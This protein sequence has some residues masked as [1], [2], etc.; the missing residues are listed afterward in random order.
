MNLPR[1]IPAFAAGR[2]VGGLM[3][4]LLVAVPAGAQDLARARMA[5]ADGETALAAG[6]PEIALARFDEALALDPGLVEAHHGRGVALARLGRWDEATAALESAAEAFPG[7]PRVHLDLGIA[8]LNA[9]DLF[10]A[11]DELEQAEA[12]APDDPRVAWYRGLVLLRLSEWGAAAA[13]F[14]RAAADPRY[15][16]GAAYYVGLARAGAGDVDSARERFAA[17]S[18]GDGPHAAAAA[19]ALDILLER[20]WDI[21]PL[22]G[23][24]VSVAGQYDSNVILDPDDEGRPGEAGGLALRG[25]LTVAPVSTSRHLLFGAVTASRSFNFADLAEQFNLTTAAGSVGYRYRFAGG[26][27]TH[28]LQAGYRYDLGLLD[29]GPLADED[30][31][32]AYREA[33]TSSTRYALDTGDRWTTV[34]DLAYRHAAFSDLRRDHDAVLGRLGQNLSFF[35]QRMK[36]LVALGGRYEDALGRGYD[37][38]AVDAALALSALGPWSLELLGL[39]RYEHADHFDSA[40]Y[41]GWG[42]GRTDDVVTVGVTVGRRIWELVGAE[43]FWTHTEHFS[44]TPTFD[45]RRDLV[46]LAIKAVFR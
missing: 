29:G 46:G 22:L 7:S 35:G 25:A 28:S 19:A 9:G 14:A 11:A 12:A 4:C 17:A 10:W 23:G 26:G 37:L 24:F 5:L 34:L 31:I 38:W 13:S 21:L 15:A 40:F 41:S 18:A 16:V 45:Y 43:V 42:A 39:V 27:L 36:L 6:S 33:H 44:T 2:V 1:R 8:Y 30:G 3:L 32:H 20:E